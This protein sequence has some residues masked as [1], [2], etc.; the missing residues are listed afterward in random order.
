MSAAKV[1]KACSTFYP[2]WAQVFTKYTPLSTHQR[3]ISYS[4]TAQGKSLL[5]PSNTKVAFEARL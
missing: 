3:F 5:F 2:V 1:K 4:Y